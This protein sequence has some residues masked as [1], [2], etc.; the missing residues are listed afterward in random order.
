[1]EINV[2]FL[3]GKSSEFDDDN[4]VVV[5]DDDDDDDDGWKN[6][7]DLCVDILEQKIRFLFFEKI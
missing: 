2:V 5:D 7:T 1:V 3:E 4:V 6:L